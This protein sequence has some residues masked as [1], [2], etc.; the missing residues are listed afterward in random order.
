[1]ATGF[2]GRFIMLLEL[3]ALSAFSAFS[4]QGSTMKASNLTCEFRNNPLGIDTR[5]PRLGWIVESPLRGDHQTAFR[6]LVA[7]TLEKLTAE[8]GDLWDSGKAPSD[9]TMMILYGGKR[10]VS[11]LS[12]FWKVMLWDKNGKAG[13]WSSVGLWSMGILDP[14]E[15]HATWVGYDAPRAATKE[16]SS[17]KLPKD[18]NVFLP[19]PRYLKTTFT[20]NRPVHRAVAYVSALGICDLYVD[21]ARV[22]EDRFTPGW[23]DYNRRVYYRTYDVTRKLAPGTHAI[24]A[25]LA[26]GW[27][28]GYLGFGAE[29]DTYGSKTRLLVLLRLEYADGSIEEVGSGRDW[30]ATT[31]PLTEA[32]FLMGESFDA[33][34]A[35][36]GLFST[37]DGGARWEPVDEGAEGHPVVQAHPAP[38]VQ[39]FAEVKAKSITSVRQGIW[40]IDLGQNFAGAIRLRVAGKSGERITLRY[41]ERLNPDGTI[42]TTNLRAAR[43][44]DTYICRGDREELWEPRFTFHGFQYVEIQG[45]SQPPTTATITGIPVSSATPLV[46][47][48]ECSDPIVNKLASNILW[49][50]RANFIDIPTDCPQRDERLG[51]TGDAQ[52]YIRSACLNADVQAFFHKWLV[53]L[54]DAQRSDGQFPMVAPLKVAEGDGGPAWADAGVICPWTIYEMYGDR[55]IL[56]AHY[57]AM[58][59]F[60][61]F[62]RGRCTPDMLPPAEFHCFGDWLNINAETPKDVIFTA[63]FARST[64]LTAEAAAVLGRTAD[65]DRYN[66]LFAKIKSV[67][68][69]AFVDSE[70]RVKGNTQTGYVLA[71]AFGLLD[72]PMK[73]K[74]AQHLIADIE[75]REWHLSTGFVGTK[76]LMLVLS[77]IGR[78]DVAYRLLHNE[79]FPSWGFTIKNG[80]TS[81]W[82]RWD[83]WTPEKGFQ[84]P[85]MNSFAHYSF[86]AVYQWMVENIGGIKNDAPGYRK[87]VIAPQPGGKLTSARVSYGSAA[88]PISTSWKIENGHMTLMVNI[89]VSASARIELPGVGGP[90]LESGKPAASQPGV[91][92]LGKKEGRY[93]AEAGN[94]VFDYPYAPPATPR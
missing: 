56:E 64:F 67:F 62:N 77:S 17:W 93:E 42:Y 66:Q 87:V 79:T 63:Y 86:G 81:I 28:S 37:D 83:G 55:S 72:E 73:S 75:S 53:D 18:K 9:Q 71:L 30:K 49:T 50:Q 51:W 92:A 33:R 31:G 68:N 39:A 70:G 48:F 35:G 80:A 78:T 84:D 65:T 22:S 40:V 20:V 5:L 12:C 91:K 52:V 24:G 45:L 60:V 88:G 54:T 14:S 21:N 29:R 69:S 6:I 13:S 8:E 44:R 23:T 43:A 57:P 25:I 90:V 19:P 58:A 89:P 41:A 16:D 1:M 36:Q 59:R 26:D 34:R 32:D 7:S 11:H 3:A 27:Y 4:L 61:E 10:L 82:E 85:G 2:F 47:S 46:G 76:D 94:Y 15:W 38:P 74:A